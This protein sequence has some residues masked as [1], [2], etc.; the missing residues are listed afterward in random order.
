MVVVIG[1]CLWD[2]YIQRPGIVDYEAPGGRGLNIA[3]N[4]HTQKI[5]VTFIGND[6]G[7]DEVGKTIKQ[8][9]D[10]LDLAWTCNLDPNIKTPVCEVWVDDRKISFRPNYKQLS[11][12]FKTILD[13]I[14]EQK[15]KVYVVWAGYNRDVRTW[16]K[17]HQAILDDFGCFLISHD[18]HNISDGFIENNL[19]VLSLAEHEEMDAAK[20][21][22]LRKKYLLSCNETLLVVTHGKHGVY[23][24][25][26]SEIK[27]FESI[28]EK[29]EN[30]LYTI[31]CGDVFLASFI[32][33]LH[34]GWGVQEA[35][36]YG[37][38]MAYSKL[39][40]KGSYFV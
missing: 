15:E 40:F 20:I 19:I 34:Q 7:Y 8:Y 6:L 3:I 24:F 17:S 11:F 18:Y 26:N 5:P 10:R 31:G 2:Q 1:E 22:F 4:L 39:K 36:H 27:H 9:L 21:E 30:L 14:C 25:L 33:K 35:I 37:Q 13:S 32:A 16:I 23:L 12:S 28:A 29:D 38:Q